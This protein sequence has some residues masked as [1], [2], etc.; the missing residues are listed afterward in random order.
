[1]A[2]SWG[3]RQKTVLV[4]RERP[5][6][7]GAPPPQPPR[8]ITYPPLIHRLG[9]HNHPV[10]TFGNDGN[11]P[12]LRLGEALVRLPQLDRAALVHG[13]DVLGPRE[14]RLGGDLTASGAGQRR[15]LP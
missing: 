5:G 9:G 11:D 10:Q 1:M 14:I 8:E 3:G 2:E 12:P 7:T 6:E 4:D 15:R 13:L